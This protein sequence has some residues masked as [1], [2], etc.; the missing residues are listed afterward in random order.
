MGAELLSTVPQFRGIVE[1]CDEILSKH[2][3][4]TVAPFL[5]DSPNY[6]MERYVKDEIVV[7]QCALFVLEFGL[8]QIWVSWGV[9]PDVVVGHR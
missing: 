8:A 7:T 4:L 9:T 3:F 1:H 5:S 6:D 2:G